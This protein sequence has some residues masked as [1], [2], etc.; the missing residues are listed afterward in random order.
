M[1]D[2]QRADCLGCAGH[3]LLRTPNMDRIAAEGARFAN[4]VTTSPLCMPARASFV[5]GL[6][7]HNHG[8]WANVG[9]LPADDETFFHR[10]QQVGYYTGY[11]GKSHFY[12]HVAGDH[13]RNHED[14]MH[15]RGIDFVHET[16]G[17]W[18]TVKTGSYMSDYWG[19]ERWKAFQGD[20]A[21]RRDNPFAVWASP[22]P[23]EDFPDSYVG[24][25]AVDFIEGFDGGQ[26]ICLFVGFGGPH[27]PFDAP[28]EY[29]GMYDPAACPAPIP[30]EPA[31]GLPPAA[32]AYV[33]SRGRFLGTGERL[34]PEGVAAVRANYYGKIS[35]ID[36]WIGRILDALARRGWLDD[37]LIVLWSDHGELAGD[38]GRFYKSVFY[39]SSV[40]V[41]LLLRW[42]GRVPA[43]CVRPHLAQTVDVFDT[44]LEAGGCDPSPRSFGRSLLP[45]AA[46]PAAPLRDAA[47]SEIA[48]GSAHDGGRATLRTMVRTDRYK[49]AVNESAEPLI[50]FDLAEDPL[51]QD[52]LLAERG[53][54]DLRRD[55]DRRIYEWLMSTQICQ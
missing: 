42:P 32:A 35:L 14:Y 7:C 26:P 12:E 11:I 18:A 43:G 41:P 2:Q 38:H 6:Y 24:R 3:P 22:L 1:T 53:H 34:D 50:L 31:E 48:G 51:E 16:T 39:E 15:A 8:M 10:L 46:D 13:L 36:A 33:G 27:E 47:F 19:P 17:P 52:N 21:R 20:Y 9:Q 40:R 30:P 28:G 54:E 37:T 45:G 25:R 5:S 4:A 29:A 44:L 49:Y 55:L 23:T